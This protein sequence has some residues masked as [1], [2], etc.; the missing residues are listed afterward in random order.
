MHSSS[1]A[2]LDSQPPL[3][4]PR[5]QLFHLSHWCLNSSECDSAVMWSLC[6]NLHT[7]SPVFAA[8]GGR[9]EWS[10]HSSWS[11]LWIWKRGFVCHMQQ[12]WNRALTDYRLKTNCM[13]SPF[14][15][16]NVTSALQ[17]RQYW[18]GKCSQKHTERGSSISFCLN[19]PERGVSVKI[20][21]HY[22][23]T[24]ECHI[25]EFRLNCFL[26]KNFGWI[27]RF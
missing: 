20:I 12:C 7:V 10:V 11:G 19:S 1:T 21:R 13:R 9:G 25:S 5:V 8:V 18:T 23:L 17:Y 3:N 26:E 4:C 2:L 22:E 16:W 14:I 6:C 24:C 15:A 27:N